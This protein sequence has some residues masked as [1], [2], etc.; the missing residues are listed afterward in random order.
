MGNTYIRGDISPDFVSMF[1]REDKPKMDLRPA[2]TYIDGDDPE[3]KKYLVLLFSEDDDNES[4]RTWTIITGRQNVFDYLKNLLITES[5]SADNSYILSGD[6]KFENALTVY[7]FMKLCIE[8]ENVY[9][10]TDEFDIEEY[11]VSESNDGSD[12]SIVDSFYSY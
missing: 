7:R 5:F 3:E 2:V 8:N 11:H 1:Q 12:I 9:C 6:Q 4:D 10:N